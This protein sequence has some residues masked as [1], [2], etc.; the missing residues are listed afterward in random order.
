MGFLIHGP[1]RP[2]K[3]YFS[4]PVTPVKLSRTRR[5]RGPPS[6]SKFYSTTLVACKFRRCVVLGTKSADDL[7]KVFSAFVFAWW[8]A[9][10]CVYVCSRKEQISVFD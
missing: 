2:V 6:P 9:L 7:L 3:P 8:E 5:A 1:G 10:A 4:V